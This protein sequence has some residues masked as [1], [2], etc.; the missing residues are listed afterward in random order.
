MMLATSS[1]LLQ[2][3]ALT[4]TLLLSRSPAARRS[5]VIVTAANSTRSVR[6]SSSALPST[7]MGATASRLL[8]AAFMGLSGC[9][10]ISSTPVRLEPAGSPHTLFVWDFDW[11]VINCNSDEYIPAQ[12]LGDQEMEKRLRALFKECKDWHV[13]VETLVNQVMDEQRLTQKQVLSAAGK[14][15]YLT[16]VRAALDKIHDKH[17]RTGQMILSD[18]NTIFI[19]AFLQD[20][21]LTDHFT[22]GIITNAGLWIDKSDDG[23]SKS[24]DKNNNSKRLQVIHQSKQY[25]GHDCDECPNNLCK[26][27]ALSKALEQFSSGPT[28]GSNI[29]PTGATTSSSSSSRP[30]IVY[31]GDGSN[32]ACPVLHVLREG[33][34]ML[35]RVG[36]RRKFANERSGPETDHEATTPAKGQPPKGRGGSFGVL[37]ALVRAKEGDP[38]IVPKCQVWEWTT[39]DELS[40]FVDKLLRDVK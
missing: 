26:T 15:P 12:F 35:A 31:V 38:P 20:N 13:C 18:G 32:D 37:P 21:G 5:N 14:M 28:I 24:L 23:A 2:R 25:G 6:F 8:G 7:T 30:R 39:G 19:G 16:G 4:R 27:Q 29:I 22:H 11:T 3:E 34:V 17:K 9:W 33:D 1:A 40:Q 36:N 10:W